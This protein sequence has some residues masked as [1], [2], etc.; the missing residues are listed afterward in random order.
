MRATPSR[1][2]YLWFLVCEFFDDL[3]YIT[4]GSL[5]NNIAPPVKVEKHSLGTVSSMPIPNAAK[6]ELRVPVDTLD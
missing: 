6:A 2:G 3:Y 4:V 1:I 5:R